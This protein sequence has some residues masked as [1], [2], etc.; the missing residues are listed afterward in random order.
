[1]TPEYVITTSD[2]AVAAEYA[3]T[4]DLELGTWKWI[5]D[6]FKDPICYK[7]YRKE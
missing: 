2:Y 5:R 7:R 4:L 1:M 3:K 6:N